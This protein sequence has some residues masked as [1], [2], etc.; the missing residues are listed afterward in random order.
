ML[1]KIIIMEGYM[2]N[3]RIK[4]KNVGI[5]KKWWDEFEKCRD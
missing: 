2:Q 4:L 5:N 3:V 1:G